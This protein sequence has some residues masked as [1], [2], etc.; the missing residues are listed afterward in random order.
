M[1]SEFSPVVDEPQ[2]LIYFPSSHILPKGKV[3]ESG[4][5]LCSE[6][7]ISELEDEI[8]NLTAS[9]QI[10]QVEILPYVLVDSGNV[11]ATS[12]FSLLLLCHYRG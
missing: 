2:Y 10:G 11:L 1:C 5:E 8:H 12:S 7:S 4:T 3:C 9:L 6:K